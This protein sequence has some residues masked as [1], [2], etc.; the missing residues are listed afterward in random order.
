MLHPIISV[1]LLGPFFQIDF[2][3]DI[4]QEIEK[5][6]IKEKKIPKIKSGDIVRLVQIY[7]EKDKERHS[8][9]EG[10]VIAI[11]SG[12]NT[13]KTITLRRVIDGVGVEKIIPLYLSN[14]SK[15]Q[16]LRSSKTRRAKLYYL[17]HLSGKK[18]RLK[19]KGLDKEVIEM[20]S[21]ESPMGHSGGSAI[22]TPKESLGGAVKEDDKAQ[23]E[24]EGEK[25]EKDD[26]EK[27]ASK[28]KNAD[29]Q[30]EKKAGE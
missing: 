5:E 16:V 29:D 23:K 9:F 15:I 2:M 4:I 26:R 17:R 18:A 10:M 8:V 30:T 20:M 3:T 21:A 6:E 22:M 19:E 14:I 1:S 24:Q 28:A 27:K 7:T 11:N 13:R 25:G 12:S